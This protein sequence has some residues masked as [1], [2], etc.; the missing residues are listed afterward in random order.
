[1]SKDTNNHPHPFQFSP[2]GMG[3]QFPM[4]QQPM[5][6]FLPMLPVNGNNTEGPISDISKNGYGT[7]MFPQFPH[8]KRMESS[9]SVVG[10]N[11]EGLK[12][13]DE[14]RHP[15]DSSTNVKDK[16]NSSSY[17]QP[18][19]GTMG[20]TMFP[21]L[22]SVVFLPYLGGFPGFLPSGLP[23]F[24]PHKV[25]KL[26]TTTTT[27]DEDDNQQSEDDNQQT[28][29]ENVNTSK[30]SEAGSDELDVAQI[31]VDMQGASKQQPDFIH[32]PSEIPASDVQEKPSDCAAAEQNKCYD[33][34]SESQHIK[35]LQKRPSTEQYGIESTDNSISETTSELVNSRRITPTENE[36]V[37]PFEVKAECHPSDNKKKVDQY[38]NLEAFP[39]IQIKMERDECDEVEAESVSSL[40]ANDLQIEESSMS[41]D[42]FQTDFQPNQ[43]KQLHELQVA[44]RH[45]FEPQQLSFECEQVPDQ[46]VIFYSNNMEVSSEVSIQSSSTTVDLPEVNGQIEQN[47]SNEEKPVTLKQGSL[48]EEQLDDSTS[49]LKMTY[50]CDV[51]SQLF[52][53]SLGLQKHIEFH[54]DDG[55]HYTCSI[56]FVQFQNNADLQ[57]HLETHTK[58]RPHKCTF[59]PKSFRDPGSLQKHVRVHTGE[60]PFDCKDCDRSFAEYS[61]L[62]KHQ[63]VHTGEQPYRCQFC[64]K[65]FSISGNLQRHI[66]IHTGERPYKCNFCPKAFNNPSHLRRHVKNLHF[67]G[68]SVVDEAM[69]SHY[70]NHVGKAGDDSTDDIAMETTAEGMSNCYGNHISKIGNETAGVVAMLTTTKP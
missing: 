9:S 60:K 3:M 68:E 48:E 64:N 36:N 12:S 37:V 47:Q 11:Q 26:P 59:C 8:I 20:G 67:K 18:Y 45:D 1:M 15:P 63:R 53:S 57:S 38:K 65:A 6:P 49:S 54:T 13:N 30:K 41:S 55:K 52:R 16:P 33:I 29:D 14:N 17:T 2:F 56:C 35:T 61:S 34:I 50:K 32:Q 24:S 40:D 70:S 66:L 43:D 44:K 23:Q 22:P 69:L 31:L 7:E 4:F 27:T 28:K 10:M 58:K 21:M 19:I 5:G 42:N 25:N 39:K 62:R 46:N 51:C